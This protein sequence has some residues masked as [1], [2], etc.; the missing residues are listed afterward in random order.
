M[1]FGF[2]ASPSMEP[3]RARSSVSLLFIRRI[4]RF[5]RDNGRP[6]IFCRRSR[7]TLHYAQTKTD[8]NAAIHTIVRPRPGKTRSTRISLGPLKRVG[9]HLRRET[10]R[11]IV[12]H[13]HETRSTGF[14]LVA[15]SRRT[16]GRRRQRKYFRLDNVLWSTAI[17]TRNWTTAETVRFNDRYA[18]VLISSNTLVNFLSSIEST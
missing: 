5:S 10:L 3:P 4:E 11:A 15:A 12:C 2:V 8:Q 18:L 6:K 13:E 14:T 16:E 17:R 1:K 9:R 7:L